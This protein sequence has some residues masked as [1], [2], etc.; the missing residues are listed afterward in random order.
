MNF[1]PSQNPLDEDIPASTISTERDV[2]AET[3]VTVTATTPVIAQPVSSI[4]AVTLDQTSVFISSASLFRDPLTPVTLDNLTTAVTLDNNLRDCC[5]TL[6]TDFSRHFPNSSAKRLYSLM[7]ENLQK[8]GYILHFNEC[9][10]ENLISI[11]NWYTDQ[12]K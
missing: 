12:K 2:L 11:Q 7:Q 10:A 6:V 4:S 3:A 8:N 5:S 9:S 1:W